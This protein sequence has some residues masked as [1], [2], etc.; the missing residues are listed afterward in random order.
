[1][2]IQDGEHA[3]LLLPSSCLID[4]N[5]S[6][7]PHFLCECCQTICRES[8]Y[9]EDIGR[10]VAEKEEEHLNREKDGGSGKDKHC[11]ESAARVETRYE[12][13]RHHTS[14]SDLIASA[15]D[16][17]HLC[18]LFCQ[19]RRIGL[20]YSTVPNAE[21]EHVNGRND[22]SSR[23]ANVWLENCH[24]PQEASAGI[25][26]MGLVACLSYE[27]SSYS[28]SGSPAHVA[29]LK[30]YM[31]GCIDGYP[32]VHSVLKLC[33]PSKLARSRSQ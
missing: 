15:L 27:T 14:D 24:G 30:Q 11:K 29:L 13:F 1:M 22:S 8:K 26:A 28:K 16:G 19:Q 7:Q 25:K 4:A 31:N 18:T 17:C 5:A 3:H 2:S 9:L 12:F 23:N 6:V 32:I 33:S 10:W 21:S 20:K